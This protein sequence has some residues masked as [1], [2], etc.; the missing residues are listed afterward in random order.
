[1]PD[2]CWNFDANQPVV[3]GY[4]ECFD[5]IDPFDSCYLH[6]HWRFINIDH[7]VVVFCGAQTVFHT[8]PHWDFAALR[9]NICRFLHE[10]Y[11]LKVQS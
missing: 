10:D 2:L 9:G 3:E 1:V 4:V 5:V 6:S 7:Y 11:A 8:S